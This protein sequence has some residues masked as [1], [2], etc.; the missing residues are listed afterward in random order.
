MREPRFYAVLAIIASL[1]LTTPATADGSPI[2][3]MANAW[4]QDETPATDDAITSTEPTTAPEATEG[5]TGGQ[6]PSSDDQGATD[7]ETTT[8]AA[9]GGENADSPSAEA[10]EDV[11]PDTTEE[12]LSTVTDLV[13]A[14]DAKNWT[15][16]FAFGV[17]IL[18]YAVRVT[19]LLEK[20]GISSKVL[21]WV[22]L[23]IGLLTGLAS[24]LITGLPWP[25]A[26]M[27]GVLIGLSGSGLWSSLG[28][29]VLPTGS[30]SST[31]DTE[32]TAST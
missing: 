10:S 8:D 13:E 12:A 19:G 23:G 14:F 3:L 17:M 31:N 15:L 18:V 21:P 30:N 26:V 20:I 7:D 29:K 4:A 32:G 1:L 22:S 11:V 5:A 6:E 25:A 16:V 9:E 24:A 2:L 28:S 27:E